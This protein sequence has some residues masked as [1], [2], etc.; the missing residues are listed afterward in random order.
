MAFP[1]VPDPR[2][3]YVRSPGAAGGA[4][5]AR[6]APRTR[7]RRGRRLLALA[8][9]VLVVVEIVVVAP[10]VGNAVAALQAIDVDWFGVAVVATVV[11]MSMFGLGRRR[12]LAAAGVRTPAGASVAAAF[13]ANALHVTLPGGAAFS[14]AYTYRWM[15]D[16]GATVAVGTW[17][18][19][20][21]GVLATGSLV[22]LGLAGALLAGR[23]G[24]LVG[25][26]CEL[27]GLL[28]VAV[29][30]RHLSRHPELVR[31]ACAHVLTRV[32]RLR[33]REPAAGAAALDDLVGQLQAVRPR[34]ADWFAAGGCAVA[35]WAFDL[36]CL[37]ACAAALQVHG[38]GLPLLLV[39]YTAGM[40]TSGLSPLPGGIGVVDATLVL[41]LTA[42]GVP[43]AAALPVVVLY[44]LISVVG[45]VAAGWVCY[46]VQQVR[47]GAAAVG[48]AAS[49]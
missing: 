1:A 6:P 20:A 10:E 32:N 48:T 31:A 40:A 24:G 30:V 13:V 35:N 2:P 23:S 3:E 17:V 43:V 22:A 25:S 8:A 29:L 36:G 44:R 18:L 45:V 33:R 5:G 14:T 41:A 27:V 37:A 49:R 7:S 19:V 42:G 16:R 11:S 47:P 21:G 26:V 15:R 4:D 9:V 46:V 38:L 28:A 12:L 39:A 34:P